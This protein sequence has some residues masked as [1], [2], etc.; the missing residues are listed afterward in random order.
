MFGDYLELM[1]CFGYLVL[2]AAALQLAPAF[3][4]LA[5]FCESKVDAYKFSRLVQRP[6]PLPAEGIGIWQIVLQFM[7]VASVVTNLGLIVMTDNKFG[8]TLLWR[9]V[10]FVL[11]EHAILLILFVA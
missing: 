7:M 8:V 4:L 9:W 6:Y 11:I 3:A 5:I 2:F 1:N 10:L